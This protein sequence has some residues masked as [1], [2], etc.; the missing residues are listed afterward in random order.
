MSDVWQLQ[1]HTSHAKLCQTHLGWHEVEHSMGWKEIN[2][3]SRQKKQIKIVIPIPLYYQTL[4]H[5]SKL[6]LSFFLF[7]LFTNRLSFFFLQNFEG[8]RILE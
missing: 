4:V 5:I 8:A 6:S 2:I 1:G 3:N 7:L